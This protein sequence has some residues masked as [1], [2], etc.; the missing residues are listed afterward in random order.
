MDVETVSRLAFAACRGQSA[1][2]FV[3]AE[4]KDWQE[5]VLHDKEYRDCPFY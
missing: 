4:L 5:W 1:N 3:P 2:D